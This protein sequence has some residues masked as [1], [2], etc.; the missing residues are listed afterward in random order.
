MNSLLSITTGTG[1]FGLGVWAVSDYSSRVKLINSDKKILTALES[2]EKILESLGI[3]SLDLKIQTNTP[4]SYQKY[5]GIAALIAG[6]ILVGNGIFISNNNVNLLE[7]RLK[8]NG[9][10]LKEVKEAKQKCVFDLRECTS[11]RDRL[12]HNAEGCRNH[13]ISVGKALKKYESTDAK[14]EKWQSHLY[15]TIGGLQ[16]DYNRAI[17]ELKGLLIANNNTARADLWKYKNPV[18]SLSEK[19]K[20]FSGLPG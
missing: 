13:L 17:R 20:I 9:I 7:D 1:L 14:W 8:E 19:I 11:T 16:L 2:Q 5:L 18:I 6:V 15:K 4:K 12:D 3:V 10:L